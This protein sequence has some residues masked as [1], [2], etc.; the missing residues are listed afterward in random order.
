MDAENLN[1]VV[2][3]FPMKK[4]AYAY[5]PET[6][7]LVVAV[8]PA[9]VN[10]IEVTEDEN[11]LSDELLDFMEKSEAG[12]PSQMLN[13]GA[14]MPAKKKITVD[15]LD[16]VPT[17]GWGGVIP[18]RLQYWHVGNDSQHS[19]HLENVWIAWTGND[20]NAD[21]TAFMNALINNTDI[22]FGNGVGRDNPFDIFF[23]SYADSLE[24]AAF[25]KQIGTVGANC[26]HV[27]TPIPDFN[28]EDSQS[29][30]IPNVTDMEPGDRGKIYLKVIDRQDNKPE[31]GK[32]TGYIVLGMFTRNSGGQIG[33]AV[34]RIDYE[35]EVKDAVDP[36]YL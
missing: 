28:A 25:L 34:I 13:S 19:E 20:N 3:G 22:S 33:N 32:A 15:S 36:I 8:S 24:F 10:S 26:A 1:V 16:D 7:E 18:I 4:D 5:N 21:V 29:S 2:N 11:A 12:A 14:G 35:A 9:S 30:D 17:E 6:G 31:K 27:S 23:D